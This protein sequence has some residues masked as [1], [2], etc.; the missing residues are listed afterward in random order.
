ML[1][2]TLML[3]QAPARWSAVRWQLCWVELVL[4]LAQRLAAHAE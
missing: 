2:L 3:E 1:G 4:V